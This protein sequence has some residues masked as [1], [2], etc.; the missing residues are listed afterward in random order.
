[1]DRKLCI[2][3]RRYFKNL[4]QHKCL[5]CLSCNRYFVKLENH[6]CKYRVCSFC[7]CPVKIT[8]PHGCK[9]S[10]KCHR[11]EFTT[12]DKKAMLEHRKEGHT[13]SCSECKFT[14]P[15]FRVT[16]QHYYRTHKIGANFECSYCSFIFS[17]ANNLRNH[18]LSA[19]V[20]SD[21]PIAE[22]AFKKSCTSYGSKFKPYKY[23][24]IEAVFDKFTPQLSAIL[25]NGTTSYKNFKANI[26]ILAIL[27][28]YD[29][30][31]NTC[32]ARNE[33]VF[34]SDSFEI[35]SLST[36]H[37]LEACISAVQTSAEEKFDGYCDLEGSGWSFQYVNGLFI[38]LGRCQPLTGGCHEEYDFKS[39]FIWD[40][41]SDHGEC[42]YAAV[43]RHFNDRSDTT[44]AEILAF[45]RTT[46]PEC[47]NKEPMNVKSIDS[48]EKKYEIGVNVILKEATDLHVVRRTKNSFD[49]VNI[50]IVPVGSG[51][52][53]H[54][55]YIEDLNGLVN[56]LR[57]AGGKYSTWNSKNPR[58]V[59]TCINCLNVFNTNDLL[60]QH[61]ISC[62][63]KKAQ[64]IRMPEKGEVL[65]F[66]KSEAR[67]KAPLI[68][69][70]D[71]ESKMDKKNL[72]ST[73]NSEELATHKIVSYSLIVISHDN[74]I[75]FERSEMDETNCLQLFM[76]AIFDLSKQLRMIM[77]RIV[78]MDLT[79]EQAE[80]FM[81]T[82]ECHIC[83]KP[84]YGVKVRD[85]CHFT[86][87]YIGPAHNLCNIKRRRKVRVPI[88]A[89]NFSN[90]DSH[91]L[92]QALTDYKDVIP[93]L[94]A[95]CFNSQ[96]FRSISF[97]LFNFLDSMQFISDSLENISN[98]LLK[99]QW[100]YE[101]LKNSGL[102]ANQYQKQLL[103]RKG[104]FP[105]ELL[106]S[107]KRFKNLKK[108]PLKS[109]FYSKLHEK[110]ISEEDYN[111]GLE[112]FRTFKCH[113][114]SEYM[115]LYN[116]L[117]VILL[118][119]AITSFRNVGFKEFGLDPAYFISLPQYG[120]QWQ[121]KIKN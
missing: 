113:D 35:S 80:E 5:K 29:Y 87:V 56:E 111:H 57:Y 6:K 106:T 47:L 46:F 25:R 70:F 41:P 99:S 81:N 40:G 43:A 107:L 64:T 23:E 48:F 82:D 74:E 21:M 121:V 22:S 63:K 105:Y 93:N 58:Y 115:M 13:F 31:T 27:D 98:Q 83:K 60:I 37:E 108:F 66:T 116:K 102:Y 9:I 11:C 89:H 45:A 112:V 67:V 36:D 39:D 15:I 24:S 95:M 54:Y 12:T 4:E 79:D 91:F 114:M 69:A 118:L 18:I 49:N 38:Q 101:V 92:L 71:F 2:N 17:C 120:F 110:E 20:P 26:I 77:Q 65:E 3:C 73:L 1:M 76:T 86:G 78:P 53:Y 16:R 109:E 90:Y 119:E 55:V 44:N 94:Q 52:N 50:L 68:G 88:Y 84:I 59:Y 97:D 96:R 8:S 117:D 28:K 51:G 75:I 7:N 14:S 33:F 34:Q 30:T 103:L 42:F 100:P 104:V 19:H 85:H 61:S 32:T 72:E 10:L 62:E